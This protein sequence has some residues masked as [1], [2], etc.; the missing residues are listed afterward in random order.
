MAVWSWGEWGACDPVSGS[1]SRGV[2]VIKAKT[3][4][5]KDC[6]TGT[7]EDICPVDCVS[8]WQPW[9]VCNVN[10]GLQSRS[11]QATTT[12]KNVRD[13]AGYETVVDLICSDVS[14]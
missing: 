6:Q 12:M 13:R 3:N 14:I 9:G 5:G 4:G 11:V 1:K 7:Q 10:T 8:T 2:N